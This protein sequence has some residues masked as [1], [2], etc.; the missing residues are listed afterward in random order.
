MLPQD[1]NNLVEEVHQ[2]C[3]AYDYN[4]EEDRTLSEFIINLVQLGKTPDEI[5]GELKE[6]VGSD[7]DLN[8]TD[9]IF[10][11][12]GEMENPQT[13]VTHSKTEN[14]NRIFAQA[15]GD[16]NKEMAP[17]RFTSTSQRRAVDRSRSRSPERRQHRP[18]YREDDNRDE[19]R[20]VFSRLGNSRRHDRQQEDPEVSMSTNV[21]D[22][23]GTTQPAVNSPHPQE[24]CKFWPSCANGE[25]CP[26]F[27]PKTLCPDYPNCSKAANE[28]MFI[29]PAG[30]PVKPTAPIQ[31]Q[32]MCRYDPYCTKPT[33]PFLHS[34]N[35]TAPPA[36]RPIH[37]IPVP[38]I[39]GTACVRPGC[40]FT[41]PNDPVPEVDIP[42]K[43]DG[44]CTRPGCFYK[45]T[46]P[47][48]STRGGNKTLVLTGQEPTSQRQFS[49]PESDI[50]E[51]ILVGESADLI[52][53]DTTK[54]QNSKP[55]T[56]TTAMSEDV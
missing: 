44:A 20:D 23:L 16:V 40:H 54:T 47:P 3:V 30:D 43:Y 13:T 8:L 15:I 27:H 12:I 55:D 41:H 24:R 49:V 21:F 31:K 29:H 6:L 38:C 19:R 36:P 4:E 39:N 22:R 42:C 50:E 28:C 34:T 53:N 7:Y 45:H 9:W 18:S 5:N 51:R 1:W 32:T 17:S 46:V 48:F 35:V 52:I 25:Q 56:E 10:A 33:C 26:Y 14:R 11:R 2:K 37:R